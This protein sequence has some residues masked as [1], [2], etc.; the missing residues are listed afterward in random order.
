MTRYLPFVLIVLRHCNNFFINSCEV[1]FLIYRHFKSYITITESKGNHLLFA[2]ILT[3]QCF[4][5][6]SVFFVGSSA[7]SNLI[8]LN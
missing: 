2:K 8:P 4:F 3:L 7:V 5:P 1:I 6:S